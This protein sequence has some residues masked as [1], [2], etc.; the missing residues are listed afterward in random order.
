MNIAVLAVLGASF[1]SFVNALVWRL[2][3]KRDWVRARSQCPHCGHQ[4]ATLD[5]VPVISWLA[6]RGR[7]RYCKKPISVQYPIVELAAT[8]V[9]V[10][11]YIYWPQSLQGGQIVLFVTWLACCIGLLALLVYDLK[12][13]LLPNNLIYPTLAVAVAG[14]LAY[15]VG[16]EPHK[17]HSLAMWLLSVLAASGIFW[18]LFMASGG[19][20]IGYGDVRLGWLTG[21]LLQTPAKS[22]LMIFVASLIGTLMIL[23]L[24]ALGKR[25]LSAKIPYGPFLIAATFLCLLFGDS[26]INWY[27]TTFLP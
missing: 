4:L 2:H 6:L 24:I 8:A 10:M 23:P 1:G 13:M 3:T 15:L 12:W 22:L 16:F 17:W 7:C 9:F 5:L 19:K 25:Q 11:S 18:L 20:W 26:I 21:T 14:K 27:K